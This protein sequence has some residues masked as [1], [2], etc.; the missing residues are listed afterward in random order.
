MF[1]IRGLPVFLQLLERYCCLMSRCCSA[2]ATQPV[3]S[4]NSHTQ[5]CFYNNDLRLLRKCGKLV[6]G[7]AIFQTVNKL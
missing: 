1:L 3:S 2:S 4:F 7:L 6:A 5:S